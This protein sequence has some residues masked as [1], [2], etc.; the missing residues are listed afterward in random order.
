M[1]G[2]F[3]IPFVHLR[4]NF[5]LYDLLDFLFPLSYKRE[6]NDINTILGGDCTSR[7]TSKQVKW[8]IL[9]EMT[10]VH[11][12]WNRMFLHYNICIIFFISC[13]FLWIFIFKFLHVYVV[14]FHDLF[15]TL[16]LT[17]R[18]MKNQ[19]SKVNEHKHINNV[20]CMDKPCKYIRINKSCFRFGD[21]YIGHGML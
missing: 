11:I 3:E 19:T 15:T 2:N 14:H 7:I 9:N 5:V 1:L 8:R 12:W 20:Y 16:F 4:L 18:T 6:K 10:D 17:A 13:L 21:I